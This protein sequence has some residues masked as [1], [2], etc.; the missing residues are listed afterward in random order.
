MEQVKAMAEGNFFDLPNVSD[1]SHTLLT[2]WSFN[3]NNIPYLS[4]EIEVVLVTQ[5]SLDR[6]TNLQA[7]LACWT[8]KASVAVYLK[9][10]EGRSDTIQAIMRT[11]N[12]ARKYA[13]EKVG[14]LKK[15]MLL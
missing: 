15:L 9:P 3:Q 1:E 14:I 11:I 5:C 12:R 6:M 10:M 7:Q 4:T 13:K 8:G 2:E